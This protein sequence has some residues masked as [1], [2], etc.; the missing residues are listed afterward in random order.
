M[1]FEVSWKRS[2]CLDFRPSPCPITVFKKNAFSFFDV[3]LTVRILDTDNKGLPPWACI[4]V[5]KHSDGVV[6]LLWTCYLPHEYLLPYFSL[7]LFAISGSCFSIVP[8]PYHKRGWNERWPR[9][10]PIY[11]E[12]AKTNVI[13]CIF[14]LW[15]FLPIQVGFVKVLHRSDLFNFI[16]VGIGDIKPNFLIPWLSKLLAS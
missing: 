8:I 10:L 11:I 3:T 7:I 4:Q 15:I 5:V 12:K 9:F 13:C 14:Q 16:V 6:V 1:Y 2:D